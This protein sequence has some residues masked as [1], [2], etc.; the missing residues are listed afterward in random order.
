MKNGIEILAAASTQQMPENQQFQWH[1]R[2]RKWI[3]I[4]HEIEK[5]IWRERFRINFKAFM[6]FTYF[7]TLEL[8]VL[9]SDI[10]T[11]MHIQIFY[12]YLNVYFV[13]VV[14]I[15]HSPSPPPSPSSSHQ[16]SAASLRYSP[17]LP[18]PLQLSQRNDNQQQ[19]KKLV[20]IFL[21]NK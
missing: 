16:S 7:I 8:I 14:N 6:H 12:T 5:W 19:Y 2:Y 20:Y 10:H 17:G 4:D 11:T 13:F 15:F 3:I 21:L 18:S 1:Y 9:Y